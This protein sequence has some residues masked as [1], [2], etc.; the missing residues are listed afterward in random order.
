ME[1]TSETS[2]IEEEFLSNEEISFKPSIDDCLLFSD[3]E[4]PLQQVNVDQKG[5]QF[6]HLGYDNV[7]F[8]SE[9]EL[10][11]ELLVGAKPLVT[12]NDSVQQQNATWGAEVEPLK[13]EKVSKDFDFPITLAAPEIVEL[14]DSD[15]EDSKNK[16]SIPPKSLQ[17]NK[18]DE[19][20][21]LMIISV[22]GPN[23]LPRV[24]QKSQKGF[25]EPKEA[26]ILPKIL[27]KI[28]LNPHFQGKIPQNNSGPSL[29]NATPNLPSFRPQNNSVSKE[30]MN[31]HLSKIMSFFN[32]LMGQSGMT[33]SAN[34]DNIPTARNLP[35]YLVTNKNA[36]P[37]INPTVRGLPGQA[38]PI[39][40]PESDQ[41]LG[42][43]LKVYFCTFQL[44]HFFF[45]TKMCLQVSFLSLKFAFFF[46]FST[47]KKLCSRNRIQSLNLERF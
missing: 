36:P 44:N 30:D 10:E 45:K 42:E 2:I 38:K 27:P 15:E 21:D 35:P 46:F 19:D 13:E 14:S 1:K 26:K 4:T 17:Q 9:P 40:G 18:N 22:K 25:K 34:P 6:P 24:S 37:G 11:N 8:P 32:N 43:I 29:L 31:S 33:T 5:D 23:P 41:I 20:D 7:D 39:L 16:S 47:P 28:P 12:N 3:I